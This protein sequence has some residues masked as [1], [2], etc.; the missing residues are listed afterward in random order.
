MTAMKRKALLALVEVAVLLV[1]HVTLLHVMADRHI[2]STIL[3]GGSHIP[4]SVAATATLF[5]VVRL[6]AV[7]LL[8]GVI[9]ARIVGLALDYQ[10]AN[11]FPPWKRPRQ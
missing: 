10:A 2:V 1:L 8:P 3:A 9:L 11:R 6:Y 4:R 7:L 5:V